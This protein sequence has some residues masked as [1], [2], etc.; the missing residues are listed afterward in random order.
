MLFRSKTRFSFNVK[1]ARVGAVISTLKK[2]RN[3]TV[4]IDP[5]VSDKLQTLVT[6]NVQEVTL[7][8][9]LEAALEPVGIAFRLNGNTLELLPK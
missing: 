2:E 3:L 9:I 7:A 8:E 6:F 4:R 5:A 1:K